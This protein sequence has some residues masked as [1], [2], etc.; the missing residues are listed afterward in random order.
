MTPIFNRKRGLATLVVVPWCFLFWLVPATAHAEKPAREEIL[1]YVNECSKQRV[2]MDVIGRFGTDFSGLDLSGVNFKGGYQASGTNLRNAD[3]TGANLT[4]ADFD[5]SYLDGADFTGADLTG[6][7]F[8]HASLRDVTLINA[9]VSG[10]HFYASNLTGAKMAGIDLSQS[11]IGV[12]QFCA[13]DLSGSTLAGA[14]TSGYGPPK[15][16]DADL[17]GADLHGLELVES[18]FQG[19]NLREADLSGCNL[20]QADFTGADLQGA[21]FDRVQVLGAV[22]HNV[23]GLSDAEAQQLNRNAARWRFLMETYV[24]AFLDSLA[25]PAVLLLVIP[26]VAV[27]AR[28]ARRRSKRSPSDTAAR[29]QFSLSSVLLLTVAVGTFI[30]VAVLS[31]TGAYSLAMVSAFCLMV[32]EVVRGH[33]GLKLSL[34][35]LAAALVY[36]PLNLAVYIVVSTIDASTIFEPAFMIFVVVVGPLLAIGSSIAAAL[37]VWRATKRFQ[38]MSLILFGIW[39][40]GIGIANIWLIGEISGSV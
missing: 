32:A 23:E 38:I 5:F 6:A 34:G 21:N 33:T 26:S 19:A 4:G 17:T 29:F 20:Q 39:M 16:Q 9:I 8:Y 1:A 3:F 31:L 27:A 7:R 11:R 36:L 14:D 22:F 13:A 30:G 15:F 12:A 2:K 25:F 10:T 18:K 35:L 40:A 24:V 37:V 28:F